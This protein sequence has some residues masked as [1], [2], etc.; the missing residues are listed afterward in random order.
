MSNKEITITNANAFHKFIC[1]RING[2]EDGITVGIVPDPNSHDQALSIAYKGE[3]K[4]VPFNANSKKIEEI[5]NEDKITTF[6]T[7]DKETYDWMTTPSEEDD[8]PG[9]DTFLEDMSKLNPEFDEWCPNDCKDNISSYME[10]WMEWCK[11]KNIDPMIEMKEVKEPT[12]KTFK[13]KP[14][15][16]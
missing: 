9:Y 16:A 8:D 15:Y 4:I 14:T 6:L 1:F 3:T 12:G 2:L 13:M 7:M 5:N 11:S 10:K